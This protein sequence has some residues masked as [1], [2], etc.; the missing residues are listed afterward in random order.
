MEELVLSDPLVVPEKVTARY[1]MIALT[2]NTKME[3]VPGKQGF[4]HIQLEDEHGGPFSYT[5]SGQAAKEFIQFI[6][7][8][9][10]STHSLTKR[11][12]NKLSTDGVLPGTVVGE[13]DGATE[14]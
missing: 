5:Y 12:L 6:N 13:P 4:V 7:T 10:F 8:A 14:I 9:D 2:M 1:K 11:V 3:L